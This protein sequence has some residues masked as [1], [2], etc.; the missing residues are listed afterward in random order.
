M[1]QLRL[2]EQR[3]YD[4][5]QLTIHQRIN[6]KSWHAKPDRWPEIYY[7][8]KCARDRI[9]HWNPKPLTSDIELCR[10]NRHNK[11]CRND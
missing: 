6:F 7:T 2:F 4:Y 11:Y 9:R 1:E 3:V 8:I 5:T 10:V